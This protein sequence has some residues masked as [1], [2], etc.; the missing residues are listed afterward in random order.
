MTNFR[1]N[2]I[3]DPRRATAGINSVRD[4]L[5]GVN[6]EANRTRSLLDRAFQ[7]AAAGAAAAAFSRLTSEALEFNTALAEVETL[8]IGTDFNIRALEQSLLDQAAAF[9]SLPAQQTAAAYDIIS[10]GASSAAEAVEILEASN[11]LAIGGVTDVG[12]AANG[13]TS[14]LNAYGDAVESA[15]DVSDILFVG[16]RQGKTTIDELSTSIGRVAPLAASAGV[17]FDELTASVAALTAGGI[18]T[19]EAVTGVRAILA[20]V[21]RPTTQS[22]EAAERL[23]IQFNTAAIEAQGF[24]GFLEDVIER[25]GGSTDEL[26]QLFGGVEALVPILALSGEAGENF[27]DTIEAMGDRAGATQEAF[28]RLANSPGFQ[29]D[30][31]TSGIVAEFTRLSNQLLNA[32]V[33]ALRFVADNMDELVRATLAVAG[34]ITVQL[35]RQAIPLAIAG[36]RALTVAIATNPFGAIVTGATLAIGALVAFSDRLRLTGEDSGTVF[37]FLTILVSDFATAFQ[38]GLSFISG[39]FPDFQFNLNQLTI[40]D[41]IRNFARGLEVLRATFVA[42]WEALVNIAI[43]ATNQIGQVVS[44]TLNNIVGFAEN[45]TTG[46]NVIGRGFGVFQ[47][48]DESVVADFG[49]NFV[50]RFEAT[51]RSASEAFNAALEEG[52]SSTPIID[53]VEGVF[54]R[55]DQRALDR[56]SELGINTSDALLAPPPATSTPGTGAGDTEEENDALAAR[57]ALI[58]RSIENLGEEARILGLVGDAR[59]I[60]LAR[61]DLEEQL[62][63]E[64]REANEDLTEAQINNLAR[65]EAAEQTRFESAQRELLQAERRAQLEQALNGSR[66]DAE[67]SLITLSQLYDQ[68]AISLQQ[69]NQELL[70]V[71]TQLTQPIGDDNTFL[72]GIEAGIARVQER[73]NDLGENIAS[74]FEGAFDS[75][76]DSIVNFAR[77]GEFSFNSLFSSITEQLL[78]LATNQLFAQLLQS[79]VPGGGFGGFGGG[80]FGALF[81]A[82]PGFATGGNFT[83]GGSGGT[84]SQLVAFRATPGEDVSVRTPGQQAAAQGGGGGMSVRIINVLDPSVVLDALNSS[85][86]EEVIVNT[87]QNNKSEVRQIL[88]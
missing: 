77:T 20:S 61:L 84:D 57:N 35:A 6:E 31:I 59:E 22:A 23:G 68:G 33:P 24:Q 83:V 45:F 78:R 64:L 70:A 58:E 37:D 85:E 34:V 74:V 4:G 18:S 79:A 11:R 29:I 19:R 44:D 8:V 67:Q 71:R 54:D 60:E 15:A 38:Q 52:L 87:I 16:V 47:E 10:A 26:A 72:G 25:T 39:L 88:Q 32:L 13:L 66:R 42:G 7:F 30:R 2:V 50:P 65:L 5:Q 17:G 28:D 69:Y 9:G 36:V 82:L 3:V 53:Y 86:G 81:N 56:A 55:A 80:G 49:I 12:T 43:N 51:G 41:V 75:A 73:T 48:I 62:R 1:I 27:A 46:L 63:Q 21:V 40:E 76:T 14:I